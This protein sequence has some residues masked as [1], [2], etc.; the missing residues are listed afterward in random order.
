MVGGN[1]SPL[2][3]GC[4]LKRLWA[5]LGVLEIFISEKVPPGVWLWSNKAAGYT[6]G[7][8]IFLSE[9]VPPRVWPWSK[10]VATLGVSECFIGEKVPFGVWLC[11]K[12]TAGN[13]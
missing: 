5:T 3:C 11:S 7:V 13:T 8:R 4:D 10:E 12:E 1:I 2:K 6:W 9:K